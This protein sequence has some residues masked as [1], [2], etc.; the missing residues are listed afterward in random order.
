V[1]AVAAE[2]GRTSGA[3]YAHFGSKAGL[4]RAVLDEG[5]SQTAVV[6][7]AELETAETPEERLA[8]L[9]RNIAQSPGGV[10]DWW[11]TLEHELWARATRDTAV[12]KKVAER[13]AVVRSQMQR[14]VDGIPTPPGDDPDDTATLVLAMLIGLEMQ[15]R[16]DPSAVPDDVA[17][18]GLFRLLSRPETDARDFVSRG[19]KSVPR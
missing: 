16:L 15:H 10:G 2:A 12:A 5:M 11:I 4:L 17:L 8:A 6:V 14:T 13:Y 1:D 3:V 9:W 7:T 19:A 18:D